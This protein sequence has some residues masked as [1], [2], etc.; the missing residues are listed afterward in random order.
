M[1]EARAQ[2]ESFMARVAREPDAV[3]AVTD[4]ITSLNFGLAHQH[5]KV[6]RLER[7]VRTIETLKLRLADAISGETLCSNFILDSIGEGFNAART[8]RRHTAEW[9]TKILGRYGVD[10]Q[11]AASVIEHLH[12]QI[13]PPTSTSASTS[14]LALTSISGWFT[15]MREAHKGRMP[16]DVRAAW[17]AVHMALV[18]CHEDISDAKMALETGCS[19]KVLAEERERYFNWVE[20]SEETLINFRSKVRSSK[21]ICVL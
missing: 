18:L 17:R 6:K 3:Q 10:V 1:Q 7:Q 15:T 8:L 2:T 12:S 19:R 13:S 16:N 20:G 14:E 11:K 5:D 21:M 9:R 4:H